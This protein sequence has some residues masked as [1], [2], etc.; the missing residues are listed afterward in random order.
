ML[1]MNFE[2]LL[3]SIST[4]LSEKLRSLIL[5]TNKQTNKQTK[6]QKPT[7]THQT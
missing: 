3:P 4:Y 2:R 1:I 7:E 6:K 5:K